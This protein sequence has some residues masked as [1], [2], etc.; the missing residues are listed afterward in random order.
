MSKMN[1]EFVDMAYLHITLR[2]CKV[3]LEIQW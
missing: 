3:A 2:C 1:D